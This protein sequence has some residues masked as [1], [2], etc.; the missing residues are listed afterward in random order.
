MSGLLATLL[1]A[2]QGRAAVA[3]HRPHSRF[4]QADVLAED[5][6]WAA[7]R[8]DDAPAESPA[9]RA[10]PVTR[11]VAP[12]AARAP[13]RPGRAAEARAAPLLPSVASRPAAAEAVPSRVPNETPT[14]IPK[15]QADIAAE[16]QPAAS[17]AR[18]DSAQLLPPKAAEAPDSRVEPLLPPQEPALADARAIDRAASP[19]EPGE[20]ILR[21]DTG[22]T[23]RIGRIEVRAAA[24]TPAQSARPAARPVVT[25]PVVLPRAAVRQSLDDYRASRKR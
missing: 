25:R 12:V 7:R 14:A 18:Q 21:S 5:I 13:K 11:P 15:S 1:E 6:E 24:E 10:A 4:E 3:V 9:R 20:T 23:L 16:P 17:T 2:A 8:D 22:F 19:A